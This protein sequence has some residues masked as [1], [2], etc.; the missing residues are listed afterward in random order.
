M[1]V[2]PLKN[3]LEDLQAYAFL[4]KYSRCVIVV[5][6]ETKRDLFIKYFGLQNQTF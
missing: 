2:K 5:Y 3:T 1:K 4:D 6:G